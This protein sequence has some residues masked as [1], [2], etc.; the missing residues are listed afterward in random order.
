MTNAKQSG[1]TLIE[2][3]VV[4]TIISSLAFL[5]YSLLSATTKKAA[6][7]CALNEMSEVKKVIRG[8]FYLDLGLIPEDLGPDGL[9]NSGDENPQ[10]AV[11]Y[12]C[13]QNDGVGNPQYK[14]M[15]NFLKVHSASTDFLKWDR[16]NRRGWR[17]PYMES[18]GSY[19]AMGYGTQYFPLIATP[20]VD[21]CEEMAV[22]EEAVGYSDK[23]EVYRK[24]KYY[25]I[26]VEHQGKKQLK[27]TAKIICFG[28]NCLDDGSYFNEK[29]GRFTTA[30]DLKSESYD[31]GDD[32]AM[33]IFGSQPAR[34]PEGF[35]SS[36]WGY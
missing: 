17:G 22:E 34:F 14:D 24:G 7:V 18:D 8:H 28:A 36:E 15:E 31:T 4:M 33:S 9:L 11:R 2:V 12:L 3:V 29:K 26:I 25:H 23:A 6:V 5:V 16:Y 20:W 1:F 10:Y 13:I 32:I 27:H 35:K 21:V 19:N 30:D